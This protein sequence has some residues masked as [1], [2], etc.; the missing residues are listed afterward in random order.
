VKFF[1]EGNPG[2]SP[3]DAVK[4]AT[5]AMT[6]FPFGFTPNTQV[7]G[8]TKASL[9]VG[10][11]LLL[12]LGLVALGAAVLRRSAPAL[13][14]LGVAAAA[15]VLA[16]AANTRISG[17]IHDYLVVWQEAIPGA[18]LIA[19]AVALCERRAP[20][21]RDVVARLAPIALAVLALLATVH[22]ARFLWR[23][24][25]APLD[26]NAGVAAAVAAIDPLLRPEDHRILL[27]IRDCEAWP[28]A[29]GVAVDLQ[30]HG[31]EVSVAPLTCGFADFTTYFDRFRLPRG[32]ETLELEW[33]LAPD[34]TGARP[35]TTLQGQ[36]LPGTF[37]ADVLAWRYLR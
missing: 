3:K 28:A 33:A 15:A 31:R 36:P 25:P 24:H 14:M 1:L 4:Q 6:A 8:R 34:P 23:G 22:D 13:A 30:R 9:V 11:L 12:V 5:F 37:I 20:L 26:S 27:T 21:G 10:G 32:D 35:T 7:P 18:V 17:G 19:L 16:I 2:A 29:A